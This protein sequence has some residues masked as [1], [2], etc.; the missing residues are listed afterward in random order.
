MSVAEAEKRRQAY[1]TADRSIFM[2]AGQRCRRE[3]GWGVIKLSASLLE[4]SCGDWE[5]AEE[6]G[7]AGEVLQ[8]LVSTSACVQYAPYVQMCVCVLWGEGS[9]LRA[10]ADVSVLNDHP[11]CSV[12]EVLALRKGVG[13]EEG[14]CTAKQYQRAEQNATL[15]TTPPNYSVFFLCAVQWSVQQRVIELISSLWST[16]PCRMNTYW[17][18]IVCSLLRWHFLIPPPIEKSLNAQY[19]LFFSSVLILDIHL[20]SVICEFNTTR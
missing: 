13:E 18:D 7:K 15:S 1:N 11:A 5:G 12:W 20:Q 8:I 16:L 4:W 6:R 10:V 3:G 14:V 2:V 19:R 17:W 9:L